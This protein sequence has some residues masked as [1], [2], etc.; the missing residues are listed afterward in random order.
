MND[1]IINETAERSVLSGLITAPSLIDEVAS[2]L[3]PAHF[4]D[5]HR[6]NIFAQLLRMTAEGK[7]VNPFA[8]Y[9]AL[10]N[11]SDEV[12]EVI[13]LSVSATACRDAASIL[14]ESAERKTIIEKAAEIHK[15]LLENDMTASEAIAAMRG[16]AEDEQ[17]SATD[18][19]RPIS[20][21]DVVNK[22]KA[23]TESLHTGYIF[24]SG[25][26]ASELRIPRGAITLICAPTSH[27]KSTFMRQLALRLAGDDDG[28]DVLYFSLEESD[29]DVLTEMFTTYSGKEFSADNAK[30]LEAY[31]AKGTERYFKGSHKPDDFD[32]LLNNFTDLITSR[33]LNVYFPGTDSDALIRRIRAYSRK[34]RIKAVFIDYIQ[35]LYKPSKT[36]SRKDE[37]RQI[38]DEI[39]EM[40]ISLQLPIILG[41][42]LRRETP[43]PA[44]L[45]SQNIADAAEIERNANTIVML[46][47]WSFKPD[48]TRSNGWES[49]GRTTDEAKRLA[50]IVGKEIGSNDT[51]LAVLTKRR[52]GKRGLCAVFDF[53][54][55]TGRITNRGQDVA[56]YNTESLEMKEEPF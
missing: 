25:R 19:L 51:I 9:S 30:T 16:I 55:N 12:A 42:Q 27:G 44:D 31:F 34:K 39:R 3:K 49:A 6:R 4:S 13:T 10:P 29:T 18:M 56:S 15:K 21:E 35:Q 7:E 17:E 36:W 14:V 50:G 41:A 32:E 43:S 40:C 5:K 33:R 52:R 45:H 26:D 46:W 23:T 2:Y 24:G 1:L 53:N 38:C 47:N 11:E 37:L 22:M 54:G 28:G 20:H 8:L 48:V